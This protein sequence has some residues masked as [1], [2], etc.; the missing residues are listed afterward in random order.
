MHV[1]SARYSADP[2]VASPVKLKGIGP[3]EPNPEANT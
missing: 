1:G 2:D 3:I